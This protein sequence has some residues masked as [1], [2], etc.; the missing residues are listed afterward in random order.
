MVKAELRNNTHQP[1]GPRARFRSLQNEGA[2]AID[3]IEMSV[4][5]VQGMTNFEVDIPVKIKE[6]TA[7]K[8]YELNF[9]MHN[10]RGLTI[11][12]TLKINLK[13]IN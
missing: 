1:Y 5:L 13:V 3:D 7:P 12:E 2:S 9:S 10:A 6:N 11:G 4:G 8:A